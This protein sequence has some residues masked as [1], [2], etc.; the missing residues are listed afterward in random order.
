[1]P[2]DPDY[3][4]TTD[5]TNQAITWARS[6]QSLTPDKPFFIYFATGATHAPHHVPADWVDRHKGKFDEGWDAHQEQTLA[7]QIELGVVPPGTK[8]AS[9]PADIAD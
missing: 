7:R 9:K 3:H 6:Q 2:D 5:M 4:F 8:L 1:L